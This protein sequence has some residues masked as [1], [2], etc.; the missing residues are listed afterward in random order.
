MKKFMNTFMAYLE[1]VKKT[2]QVVD[3]KYH[4]YLSEE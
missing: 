4:Q 3:R 1:E 2:Y